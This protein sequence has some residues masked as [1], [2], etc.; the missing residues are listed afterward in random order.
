MCIGQHTLEALQ[1]L[2]EQ[3]ASYDCPMIDKLRKRFGELETGTSDGVAPSLLHSDQIACTQR[4]PC[5]YD[6]W[7]VYNGL[8]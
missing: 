3:I 2:L 6:C 1:K 5:C 8:R 7:V 4:C